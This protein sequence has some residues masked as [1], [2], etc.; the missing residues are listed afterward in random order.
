MFRGQGYGSGAQVDRSGISDPALPEA[1]IYASGRVV[2]T[3][4]EAA[5]C[6]SSLC[7]RLHNAR[8]APYQR[9]LDAKKIPARVKP[10]LWRWGKSS[11]PDTSMPLKNSNVLENQI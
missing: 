9:L 5:E 10:Q 6:E 1:Y 2:F 4:P 7:R 3:L 11:G 8:A